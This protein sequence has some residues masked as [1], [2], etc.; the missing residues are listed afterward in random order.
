M[1][2]SITLAALL[3]AAG[4]VAAQTQSSGGSP[5]PVTVDN[6]VRAESDLYFTSLVKEGGLGK[7]QHRREPASIDHQ[8]VI[9]LNRDTLYTSGV[10]DLD[11][12]PVTIG[13]PDPGKRFMALQIIN[14]D[15][16][17]PNVFYGEGTH[18]LTRESVGTRYVAVAI[19]TLV[20]PSS[21]DDIEQVHKLQDSITVSQKTPG[22]LDLPNW[23]PVSQQKV[24]AALLVLASTIPDFKHAFGTKEEVDPVR[25][26]LGAAAAWGGNPDRDATYLNF[27]PPR[28]DGKTVYRLVVK[29]VP[30]DAFWSVSLYNA[31][32]YFQK[33]SSNAYSINDLT[34][35][36]GADGSIAIQF[37]GCDGHVE[38]CLP[39][40]AGW[41]YTVRLYRPRAEILNGAWTFP[42]ATPVN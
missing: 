36:K 7:L 33:N 31:R 10:F 20:E 34:A 12:G 8:T 19:R 16:Y 17:V 1:K 38:N 22:K 13:M 15:Q 3:F 40:V 2:Y 25:H 21:P 27:T 4:V 5:V 37:G 35:K 39:I 18:V 32:G 28:N 11:A 14:E 41:N 29:N 24:R 9:R 26:L 23:D 30:V 6:F 42:D